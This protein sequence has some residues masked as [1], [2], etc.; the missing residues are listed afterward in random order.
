MSLDKKTIRHIFLGVIGCIV[1][2]W[3]L[4]ETERFSAVVDFVMGVVSPFVVGG[5][6][7]F[8]LNVPMRAI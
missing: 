3:L 2:Y 1:L 4:H 6:I 8:I 7:A 5:A